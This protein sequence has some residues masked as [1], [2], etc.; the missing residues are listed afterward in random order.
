MTRNKSVRKRFLAALVLCLASAA[1]QPAQPS[2]EPSANPLTNPAGTGGTVLL[3]TLAGPIDPISARYVQRGLA[4]AKEDNDQ[5]L[6]IALD[7]PGGLEVSMDQIVQ[8][9]LSSHV[10]VAV[11][12]SPRGARAASAGVFIAMAAHICAMEPGTHIGAAHPVAS[13]G[14]DI[15]GAEGQKVLNDSVAR[16]KSIAQMRGRS[17]AWADAA[18]RN[19]RSLT[20]A[21]AVAAGVADLVAPDLEGL[22]SAIDGRTVKTTSGEKVLHTAGAAVGRYDMGL[23]DRLLGILVNPDLAYI[24]MVVGI[25]GIIFELSAPGIGAPG[26][27]GGIAILLSMVGF[28]SLPTNLGGVLFIVLAVVLFIVDIKVPSHGVWTAGGIVSFVLGSF[29]LFPPWR[30]PAFPAAPELRVSPV[31]IILMTALTSLFFIFVIS[32]GVAAHTRRVSFG[33]EMLTGT[34]GEAV[35]DLAADGLVRVAGEVWSARSAGGNI[36]A[37]EAV[38]VTGREGLRLTV[39]RKGPPNNNSQGGV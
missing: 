10:P 7:T 15:P 28:G 30:P 33:S 17:T 22:L 11:F 16:L 5:L 38:E 18:V 14:A 1:V 35:T 26:I 2:A 23:I 27:A 8:G 29:L 36:R 13:G 3:L 37:G 20:D 12:V 21:E 34:S 25:F 31:T 4:R 9:I 24:L 32:K 19:S 39:R 6:V